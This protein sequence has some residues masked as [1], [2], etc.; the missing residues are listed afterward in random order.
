M[1][2]RIDEFPPKT[3]IAV[4]TFSAPEM[5][6]AYVE[7]HHLEIPVLID[8][9]LATYRAYGLERGSKLRVWGWRAA[10]RYV[11][12]LWKH[13]GLGALQ[14][15]DEDTLQLGGD[16]VIDADGNLAYGFWGDGPDDRPSV[17][18]LIQVLG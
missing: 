8:S 4:V 13:K 1:R 17:T 11:Q 14:S 16:F 2:E 10:W 7:H 9:E 18:E 15:T 3:T 6:A 12:I 5:V